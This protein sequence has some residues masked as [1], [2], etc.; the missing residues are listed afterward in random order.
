[1]REM[2]W[3]RFALAGA[4]VSATMIPLFLQ[5]LNVISGDGPV[6]WSELTDDIP[7]L[8]VLGGGAAATWLALAQRAIYHVQR[9]LEFTE[10]QGTAAVVLCD[11][12]TPDGAAYWMGEGDLWRAVG[13][14]RDVELARYHAVIHLRTPSSPL[15]YDDSNPLRIETLGEARAIDERIAGTWAGHPRVFEIP[16]TE[17]FLTKAVHALRHLRD[18]MPDCCRARVRDFPWPADGEPPMA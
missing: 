15:A 2:S 3:V 9:A 17:D 8:A 4:V 10:E 1:M 11:R 18:L 5:L 6:A 12:G 16:A 14:T 7:L 13:T